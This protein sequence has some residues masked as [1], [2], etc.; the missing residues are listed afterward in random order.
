METIFEVKPVKICFKKIWHLILQ[1][2][3][4]SIDSL[5]ST[6][7]NFELIAIVINEL[8]VFNLITALFICRVRCD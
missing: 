2:G 1:I 7:L 5:N 8:S 4:L 6:Q 3:K